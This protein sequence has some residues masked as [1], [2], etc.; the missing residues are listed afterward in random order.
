VPLYAVLAVRGTSF[1]WRSSGRAGAEGHPSTA[2][3][4]RIPPAFLPRRAVLRHVSAV[5]LLYPLRVYPY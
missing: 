1:S 3:K 2:V 5:A 4:P